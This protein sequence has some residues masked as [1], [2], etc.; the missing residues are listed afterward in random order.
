MWLPICR[1]T[2]KIFVISGLNN[3]MCSVVC[4]IF[5]VEFLAELDVTSTGHVALRCVAFCCLLRI[6]LCCVVLC[7]VVLCCVVL[8]CDVMCCD[9]SLT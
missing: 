1:K 6:A 3:Q 9:L 7:C 8:C 5:S 2:T 4:P